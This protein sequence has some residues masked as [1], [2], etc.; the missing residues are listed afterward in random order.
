MPR[1]V[2]FLRGIEPSN[3]N[4]RNDELRGIGELDLQPG[5]GVD[6]SRA[7]TGA[8]RAVTAMSQFRLFNHL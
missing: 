7:M 4:M 2:A 1:Y 6:D 5:H 8:L 3:P